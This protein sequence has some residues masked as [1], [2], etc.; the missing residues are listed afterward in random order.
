MAQVATAVHQKIDR[1]LDGLIEAW[2]GVPQAVR[3]IDQWDWADQVIYI[4]EWAIKD[5]QALRLR[6]LIESPEAT[7]EQRQRYRRLEELMGENRTILQHLRE[8]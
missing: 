6:D 8:S 7:D 3:D 4:E 2:E 1:L 5:S